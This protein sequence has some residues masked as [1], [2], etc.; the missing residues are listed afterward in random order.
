VAIR[1]PNDDADTPA[2]GGS[3]AAAKEMGCCENT[4]RKWAD[5][6]KIPYVLDSNRRRIFDLTQLRKLKRAQRDGAGVFS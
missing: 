4:I 6:G 5:T 2:L 3:S 1:K